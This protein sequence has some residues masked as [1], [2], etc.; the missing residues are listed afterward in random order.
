[1][2]A[3]LGSVV[4]LAPISTPTTA[5]CRGSP[6]GVNHSN[7]DAGTIVK[8]SREV[9]EVLAQITGRILRR[10]QADRPR[11]LGA[12]TLFQRGVSDHVPGRRLGRPS[13]HFGWSLTP[14]DCCWRPHGQWRHDAGGRERRPTTT[15]CNLRGDSRLSSAPDARESPAAT[16]EEPSTLCCPGGTPRARALFPHRVPLDMLLLAAT[17]VVGV[18]AK[19]G[20]PV[21]GAWRS[22]RFIRS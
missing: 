3:V 11:S 14:R 9:H 20:G 4:L 19:D 12:P 2:A 1:M 8:E 5:F 18:P 16:W 7:P 6:R 10:F 21:E 13:G 22:W 17:M 15:A